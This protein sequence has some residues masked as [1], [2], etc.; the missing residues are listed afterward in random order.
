MA[1]TH[2]EFRIISPVFAPV[3]YFAAVLVD[4]WWHRRIV[5]LTLTIVAAVVVAAGLREVVTFPDRIDSSAGD[6]NQFSAELYVLVAS[7]PP[8]ASI[9]T[10][11]PQR[12]WWNTGRMPTRFGFTEPL[13]G[14]SHFPLGRD[15]TLATSCAATT[16]LAWFP[17]LGNAGGRSPEEVRPDLVAVVLPI[18][19]E[20]V[21]RGTLYFLEPVAPCPAP[22]P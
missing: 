16:Y 18:E 1:G 3:V 20:S 21:R 5:I 22:E 9:V 2:I 14:N 4:R 11:N 6:P 15:D 8:D 12:V 19:V 13:P 17:G 10:N 7:L